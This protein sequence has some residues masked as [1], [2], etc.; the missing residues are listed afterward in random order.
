MRSRRVAT[1]PLA[2]A[3][4]ILLALTPAIAG[5]PSAA[6]S[7]TSNTPAIE[8]TDRNVGR[9]VGSLLGRYSQSLSGSV[10]GGLM[11]THADATDD[12]NVLCDL[13]GPVAQLEIGRDGTQLAGGWAWIVAETI[14]G[15][16]FIKRT[17]FGYAVKA[18]WLRTYSSGRLGAAGQN[19]AGAEGSLSLV[20]VHL[21][22][23]LLRGTRDDASRNEWRLSGAVG[24]GF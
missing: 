2:R 16:R 7:T 17:H 11:I 21:S 4:Y 10:A 18:V 9:V 23:A 5:E 13:R 1:G 24:W 15:R 14:D 8:A 3:L 20:G 6:N 12:C 19:W 22:V